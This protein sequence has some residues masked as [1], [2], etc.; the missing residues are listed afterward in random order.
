METHIGIGYQSGR[1]VFAY[2]G[3]VLVG[4][5]LLTLIVRR[6]R[7]QSFQ[8]SPTSAPDCSGCTR[9]SPPSPSWPALVV[10]FG[11]IVTQ[12]VALPNSSAG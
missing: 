7:E 8:G 2:E 9:R 12:F 10:P 11:W 4:F 1:S 6:L 5:P 3:C